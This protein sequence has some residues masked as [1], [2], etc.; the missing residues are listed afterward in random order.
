MFAEGIYSLFTQWN[1]VS[2]KERESVI[3]STWMNLEDIA[4]REISQ[5]QREKYSLT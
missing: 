5:A 1:T 3:V 2:L 4:L